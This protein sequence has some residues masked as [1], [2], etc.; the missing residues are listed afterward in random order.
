MGEDNMGRATK[1]LNSVQARKVQESMKEIVGSY[2]TDKLFK[3]EQEAAKAGAEKQT[4]DEQKTAVK[5]WAKQ[6]VEVDNQEM[7]SPPQ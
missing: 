1:G 7:K 3:Q 5:P 6:K 4:N 2:E